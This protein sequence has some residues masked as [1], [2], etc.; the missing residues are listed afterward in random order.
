M[1]AGKGIIVSLYV[2]HFSAVVDFSSNKC[3]GSPDLDTITPG[4][5]G[6][7]YS[8]GIVLLMMSSSP[9][10][11]KNYSV[12]ASNALERHPYITNR[13]HTTVPKENLLLVGEN[14]N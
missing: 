14:C 3:N 12:V 9:M 10:I 2:Y 13:M 1:G 11:G 5:S 6:E 7:I 4:T 8:E